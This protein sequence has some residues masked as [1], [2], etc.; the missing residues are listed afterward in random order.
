MT[1]SFRKTI[2]TAG[3]IIGTVQYYRCDLFARNGFDQRCWGNHSAAGIYDE[4]TIPAPHD[5]DITHG[6]RIDM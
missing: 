3:M 1:G 5:P 4:I 6:I 2:P